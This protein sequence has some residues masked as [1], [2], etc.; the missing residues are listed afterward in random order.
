M[1]DV[2]KLATTLSNTPSLNSSS[3]VDAETLASFEQL[4]LGRR[5]QSSRNQSPNSKWYHKLIALPAYYWVLMAQVVV[6]LPHAAHLPSWL[7]V[8]GTVSIIAQFPIVKAKFTHI[9]H[10]KRF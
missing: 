2:N 8:F 3:I 4:A 5:P 7:M 9:R 6:V 10:L 1:T